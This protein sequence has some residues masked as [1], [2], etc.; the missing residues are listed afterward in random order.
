MRDSIRFFQPRAV[1]LLAALV[2]TACGGGGGARSPDL[3][4]PE[5][6]GFAVSC[7]PQQPI[8]AGQTAQ[9]QVQ[10][11]VYQVVDA[12][13]RTSTV[14][15]TCPTPTW[16]SSNTDAATVNETGQVTAV[17]NGNTTISAT[18]ESVTRT[19][20]VTTF[21]PTL[22]SSTISC[23]DVD[24]NAGQTSQCKFDSCTFSVLAPDGSTQNQQGTCPT[25][26]NWTVTPT[27]I[28]TINNT[29]LFRSQTPGT[30]TVRA[31]VGSVNSNAVTIQVGNA[32]VLDGSL[33][34]TP[35]SRTIVAG[36]QQTYVATATF[37]DGTNGEFGVVTTSTTFTSNNPSAAP[38]PAGQ[39]NATTT[40]NSALTA[41]AT[42]TVTGSYSAN[43]CSGNPVTAT[44][45]LI[46]Q[47]ARLV[48]GGL[49]LEVADAGNEFQD[50]RTD[51]GACAAVTQ[52]ELSVNGTRQLRLRGRFDNGQECNL[53][54]RSDASFNTSA[55][56]I[57]TVSNAPGAGLVR[58][59]GRGTASIGAS[60]TAAGQT[61][62]ANP[63]Q[64]RVNLDEILGGNSVSVSAKSLSE[65][66]DPRKFACV[67]ATD[68]VGGLANASQ[69]QGR[70][71]VYAG[72]RFCTE[73]NYNEAT[74]LCEQFI[75]VTPRD[76]TNDDGDVS[77]TNPLGNRIQWKHESAGFW[78]GSSCST[79]LPVDIPFGNGPSALVGDQRTPADRYAIGDR[80]PSEN[81]VVI[82][83]GNLRLG[84]SCIT[85]EY[86][87]P[88]APQN[89]DK[90]GMTV[91]VLPVTNDVLLGSSTAQ[92]TTQ[93][94]DALAPLFLLGA[95]ENG[96]NGAITQLLSAVT[97][98]VNP[99]L[100]T[101]A[102]GQEEG[103]TGPIPLDLIV[104][105]LLNGL[106]PVTSALFAAGLTDLLNIV[107]N[108]VFQPLTC[109]LG[110]LLDAL[111]TA[112]PD[113][114][115]N[116]QACLP[117]DPTFPFPFAAP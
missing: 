82:G 31:Q 84:F 93:L 95:S 94:C 56:A 111:L 71:K 103:N 24:I 36:Q 114:I 29:G 110:T 43:T 28:G 7:T 21:T 23:A 51:S 38:F 83:A 74:G 116:A 75:D 34:L 101:L 42:V 70:L 47:P 52:Q 46:V 87:N 80:R 58:G 26:A 33:Q 30:A 69:L 66:G 109:G 17:G 27:T 41:T 81:G 35:A 11:C 96:G 50:C 5:L 63:I 79:T 112:Q 106:D 113:K 102:S 65:P 2:L 37:S 15:M 19:T 3:P 73:A 107:D 117:D 104:S 40:T 99:L 8:A 92:Q 64:F 49:C 89:T 4:F 77:A 1:L 62:N 55:A 68:L 98:I 72:A 18:I 100:Q 97:E 78:N 54:N 39:G 91:L 61:A 20:T 12:S 90:D 60:F 22:V 88:G 25:T 14:P 115:L 85:A 76:V 44:A 45:T 59:V 67:G 48:A 32:C 6:Q 108:A 53:T 10:N 16:S 105:E 86:A 9:C 57:A 13:G